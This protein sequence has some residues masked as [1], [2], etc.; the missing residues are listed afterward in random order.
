MP[1]V[2]AARGRHVR[3]PVGYSGRPGPDGSGDD[4]QQRW[5]AQLARTTGPIPQTYYDL[6]FGDGRLQV[7]LTETQGADQG[8]GGP[9]T[10]NVLQLTGQDTR[11]QD[12]VGW[13]GAD[14]G[15]A[16]AVR[17]AQR[18][19]S[20]ADQQAAE[21]RLEA[22][23]QA[24]AIREAAEREAVQIREQTAAEAA[25]IREGAE[26]EAAEIKELAAAQAAAIRVAAEREAAELRAHLLAMSAEMARVAAYVTENLASPPRPGVKTITA[27]V[28]EPVAE[29]QAEPEATTAAPPATRPATAPRRRPAT[30]PGAR[31]AT[32][33]TAKPKTRQYKAMRRISVAAAV[34]VLFVGVVGAAEI[35]LHGF[36]FFVFR[37][38]GTGATQQGPSSPAPSQ[39][40]AA[41]HPHRI[42]SG[43][44]DL[45]EVRNQ[46]DQEG[47]DP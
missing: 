2:P 35:D 47:H 30:R 20:D 10:T 22:S 31:P 18:I 9:A 34:L 46:Q 41:H 7:M 39:P 45:Q 25:P 23:A 43:L 3:V 4:T 29:P 15:N 5:S 21:I 14:P 19:L 1:Q 16:D 17:L 24:A 6:A 42:G 33:P 44:A 12:A 38:A 40:S 26:R 8:W 32:K 37:S 13:Q 27:P 28:L 11:Q 36:K